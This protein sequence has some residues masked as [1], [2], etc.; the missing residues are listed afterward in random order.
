MG[1]HCLVTT[2]CGSR[3][4]LR[5]VTF[6]LRLGRRTGAIQVIDNCLCKGPGAARLAGR[7]ASG[8]LRALDRSECRDVVRPL[9]ALRDQA[10]CWLH[11]SAGRGVA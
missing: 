10:R 5:Q 11:S 4:T 9:G 8:E 7:K 2:R 6:E 3:K 1:G